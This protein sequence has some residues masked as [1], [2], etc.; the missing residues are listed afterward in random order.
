MPHNEHERTSIRITETSTLSKIKNFSQYYRKNP[1][2]NFLH[3]LLRSIKFWKFQI[4]LSILFVWK[5]TIFLLLPHAPALWDGRKLGSDWFRILPRCSLRAV[6]SCYSRSHAR[7]GFRRGRAP[8][9][10]LSLGFHK[11]KQCVSVRS[12]EW[13][14]VK[15]RAKNSKNSLI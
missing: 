5:R 4:F 3:M 7:E 1:N 15:K 13:I 6:K 2:L 9:Y 12:R 10:Y 14:A 11:R 8:M